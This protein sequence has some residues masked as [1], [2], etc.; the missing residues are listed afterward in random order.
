MGNDY[1]L[2]GS[3]DRCEVIKVSGEGGA[4]AI[5]LPPNSSCL[6]MDADQ[7]IVYLVKTDGAGY[8]T[9]EA[10]EYKRIPTESEKAATAIEQIAASLVAMTEKLNGLDARLTGLEASLNG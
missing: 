1:H 3:Q 10:Y 5:K 4:K 9:V 7:P 6:C 8:A 2:G